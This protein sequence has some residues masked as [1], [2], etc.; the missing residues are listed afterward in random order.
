MG[1]ALGRAKGGHHNDIGLPGDLGT[2]PSILGRGG[3]SPEGGNLE[4]GFPLKEDAVLG[5]LEVDLELLH[6]G[7]N[8]LEV[9]HRPACVL[10][11]PLG[12]VAVHGDYEL[13][14]G[15]GGDV[16]MVIV[17]MRG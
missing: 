17:V 11:A 10:G 14:R 6:V 3:G 5:L 16:G 15:G 4:E 12:L 7:E 8:P 9:R 1:G 13:C 2:S